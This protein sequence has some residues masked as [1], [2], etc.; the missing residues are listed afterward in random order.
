M[1]LVVTDLKDNADFLKDVGSHGRV[2]G[3]DELKRLTLKAPSCRVALIG[4]RG[5]SG[6][7]RAR[8]AM[9]D[10]MGRNDMG[11]FR[12]PL[13]MIAF[14][15]DKDRGGKEA[16]DN[17][18]FLLD[19]FMAFFE[20]RTL[21]LKSDEGG[22]VMITGFEVLY[23]AQVDDQGASVGAVSWEQEVVFGKNLYEEDLNL[24]LEPIGITGGTIERKG[25]LDPEVLPT[26]AGSSE[27][28]DPVHPPVIPEDVPPAPDE[29][30][31][32]KT[33]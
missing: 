10:T 32:D 25:R 6:Q 33:K 18:I 17:V 21:G 26:I 23:S 12:G 5:G 14:L 20:G 9:R 11:Q 19:Q 30:K 15:V 3:N 7:S 27:V 4:T 22:P 16:R 8:S 13:Q 29:E 28:K 1:D 24:L 2:F 31:K